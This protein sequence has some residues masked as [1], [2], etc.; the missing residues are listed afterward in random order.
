MATLYPKSEEE[1]Q[2]EAAVREVR[3]EQIISAVYNGIGTG[4]GVAIAGFI[5]T[6]FGRLSGIF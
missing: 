5:L 3:K 4:I 6:L 2:R 1:R